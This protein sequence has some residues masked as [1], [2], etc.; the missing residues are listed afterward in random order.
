M[1]Q[2]MKYALF[3]DETRATLDGPDGWSKCWI[4]IGA[5]TFPI[6]APSRWRW[7]NV[8]GRNHRQPAYWPVMVPAGV[9]IICTAYCELLS[10][11]E[12]YTF[13]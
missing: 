10:E 13:E 7:Y 5:V 3:T 6:P 12:G 2:D 4:G 8:V 1:K 11:G 9:K